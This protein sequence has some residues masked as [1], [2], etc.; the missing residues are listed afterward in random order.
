MNEIKDVDKDWIK[1][2]IQK[3]IKKNKKINKLNNSSIYDSFLMSLNPSINYHNSSLDNS[4]IPLEEVI[5]SK[6]II[7]PKNVVCE[8][9]FELISKEAWDLF[10]EDK[11]NEKNNFDG[12]ISIKIGKKKIII[13]FKEDL[14]SMQY[15]NP[16]IK[17]IKDLEKDIIHLKIRVYKGNPDEFIKAIIKKYPPIDNYNENDKYYRL[18]DNKYKEDKINNEF[19]SISESNEND[20]LKNVILYIQK[21][22]IENKKPFFPSQNSIKSEED[23]KYNKNE[24]D[25]KEIKELQN[26]F[27]K[28]LENKSFNIN[29]NDVKYI[30]KII[31]RKIDNSSYIIASM[32]SLSQIKELVQ[33]FFNNKNNNNYSKLIF[34]F[35]DFINQLWI[36]KDEKYV[37]E[38]ISFM[39]N[40]KDY[41]KI[42][43]DFKEEKEPIIFLKEIFKYINKE[44]NNKDEKLKEEIIKSFEEISNNNIISDS[45]KTFINNN[46][47]IISK[48]FYGVFLQQYSCEKCK[49]NKQQYEILD[50]LELNYNNYINF[51]NKLNNSTINNTS[52]DSQSLND[53]FVNI[54]LD[55]FID[56]Y[57]KQQNNSEINICKCDKINIKSKKRIYKFPQTLVI[58]INWGKFNKEEGF[59]FDVNKLIFNEEIDLT[60]YNVNVNN[61]IK[62]KYKIRSIIYY[63]VINS[64]N[65]KVK[66]SKRFITSCRHLVDQ[67][68]YFY[69][70]SGNTKQANNMNR[71]NFIP[72]IIFFEKEK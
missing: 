25:N 53:S 10:D 61:I 70:P 60:K 69:Q 34:Y 47:S 67:N 54:Y 52:C 62:I 66:D 36:N 27:N 46:N 39:E 59:G 37:F 2:L 55:D 64:N 48:V 22:E 1:T 63:P 50:F 72:S 57:F 51:N 12:R 24:S 45:M 21:K 5:N 17:E 71:K 30:N 42:I 26:I 4:S 3:N 15:P 56:F 44:L 49:A 6:N 40:L 65:M 8:S 35:I 23:N 43:F 58:Y 14:Y 7:G 68:L 33:Y 11:S 13:K 19:P 28:S 38:P 41:N 16:K 29:L 9:D 20:G 18:N 32:Y 31:V